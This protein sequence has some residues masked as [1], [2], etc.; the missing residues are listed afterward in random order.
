MMATH[1]SSYANREWRI[2]L[3]GA[4]KQFMYAPDTFAA[5]PSRIG[6]PRLPG[7]GNL[8][9]AKMNTRLSIRCLLL[10]VLFVSMLLSCDNKSGNG[11]NT[12]TLTTRNDGIDL[13]G[14]TLSKV[15]GSGY[16]SRSLSLVRKTLVISDDGSSYSLNPTD[17]MFRILDG[18]ITSVTLNF[19]KESVEAADSRIQA[20][21][22][23]LRLE[24]A[25]F[26]AVGKIDPSKPGYYGKKFMKTFDGRKVG[27]GFSLAII[28]WG[29][30]SRKHPVR[31]QVDV[32][33]N[34][35][36]P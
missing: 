7:R 21:A 8:L 15:E 3:Q 20:I 27:R 17:G 16:K 13:S 26:A 4:F 29:T 14:V 35:S 36:I 9:P 31:V 28:V 22:K 5:P 11:E 10:S 1:L 32:S 18:N 34:A 23:E 33:M 19:P 24:A 2:R 12:I 25:D 6:I 30:G